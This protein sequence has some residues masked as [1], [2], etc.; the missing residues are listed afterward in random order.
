MSSGRINIFSFSIVTMFVRNMWM[1]RFENHFPIEWNATIDGQ[2]P[3]DYVH[4]AIQCE[5]DT[6]RSFNFGEFGFI[7]VLVCCCRQLWSRE[8]QTFHWLYQQQQVR[9]HEVSIKMFS[10]HKSCEPRGLYILCL[11]IANVPSI[12]FSGSRRTREEKK[13]NK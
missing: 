13:K 6:F 2:W 7:F 8:R 11:P 3:R 9:E 10:R 12:L 4:F 1:G 5:C